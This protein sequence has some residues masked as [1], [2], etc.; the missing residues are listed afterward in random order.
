MQN[1]KKSE[2][3]PLKVPAIRH[4]YE[5]L[6]IISILHSDH[7]EDGPN[8]HFLVTQ[9]CLYSVFGGCSFYKG[10]Q[11]TVLID[12]CQWLV[13]QTTRKQTIHETLF[14]PYISP[15]TLPPLSHHSHSHAQRFSKTTPFN[16]P[17]GFTFSVFN[18]FAMSSLLAD[19]L[20]SGVRK[21]L[22]STAD[23]PV[24]HRKRARVSS[25]SAEFQAQLTGELFSLHANVSV[26]LLCIH[27]FSA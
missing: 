23:S 12:A 6:D 3:G 4:R 21:R 15:V 2:H 26:A 14:R 10:V 22:S 25:M 5:R 20:G 27:T 9:L 24:V 19:V 17:S 16:D 13:K 1:D 11:H 7:S 8:R 18:R